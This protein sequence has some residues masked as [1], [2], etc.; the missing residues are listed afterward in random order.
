MSA[1]ALPVCTFAS[2]SEHTVAAELQFCEDLAR[3]YRREALDAGL[4][5]DQAT[6]YANALSSAAGLIAGVPEMAPVGRGW[7][8]QSRP[9][10]ARRTIASGLIRL[11]RL[12]K[13]R[14]SRR[15]AAEG[16]SIFARRFRCWTAERKS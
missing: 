6:E 3:E 5:A 15:T 9:A 11:T 10:V 4:S 14:T 16:T 7:F 2:A 8:Y 1:R 13:S 12:E